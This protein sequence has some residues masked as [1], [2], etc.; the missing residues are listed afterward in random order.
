[1]CHCYSLIAVTR[2]ISW[3][4]NR[5]RTTNN[6]SWVS[7]ALGLLFSISLGADPRSY[8]YMMNGW[9]VPPFEYSVIAVIAAI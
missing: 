9:Y 6:S 7:R 8:I 1:M 3:A 5:I 4:W 2:A